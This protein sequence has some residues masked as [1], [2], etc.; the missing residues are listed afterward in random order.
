[1][2]HPPRI[3]VWLRWEQSVIYFVT[4]CVHNR[5]PT[6]A[7]DKALEVLRRVSAKF[8]EWKILAAVIMPDHLHVIVTP[9]EDRGARISNFSGALKRWIREELRAEWKWP[10]GSFDRLLRSNESLHSSGFIFLKIP[11]EQGWSPIRTIG[12]TESDSMNL[13]DGKRGARPTTRNHS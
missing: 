4:I 11:C 13:E 8:Q 6:L 3:P 5:R 1:M 10:R 2:G 12:P 9:T 7:N